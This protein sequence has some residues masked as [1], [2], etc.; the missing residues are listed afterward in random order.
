MRTDP[1]HVAPPDPRRRRRSTRVALGAAV[2]V[3]LG[4]SGVY[5][6]T[7][8]AAETVV[9]GRLQAEAFSAQSGVRIEN[10][11][12][13]D[14]G[15]NVGWL[16][17]GDWLRYDNVTVGSTVT[18]R[19]ASDNTAGGSIELRLGSPTG[20]LLTTIPVARTGGWQ[21]WVTRTATV[22]APAGKQKLVA[23]MTS[24]QKSDFVN[25]NWFTVGG[26][27]AP[28]KPVATPS[29]K[30]TAKP[31]TA[32][33]TAAPTTTAPAGNTGAGWIPVDQ[34]KWQAQLT[35]FNAMKPKAI[36]GNPVR[37]A[38][39]NASCTVSH[40]RA[41]DPIV[42][43]GLPG[44]SHMHSFL[45]NDATDAF[46]TTDTLLNNAGSSCK[47]LQDRSAYWIPTLYENGKA[48]EPHGVTVYYGSRL[49]DPTRTVPFPQGFR[50]IVGD[51]KRQVATPKGAHSQFWCAGIGGEQGRSADG[52]WPVCAKTAE[53]TFQLTFP[54]CWD[55]VHLDSPDHKSHVGPADGQGKCSGK[56]PVAIPSVSFVIGYKTSGSS[57][58][59]KLSSGNA[60]SMHGDAFLAW[61]NAALG[62]RVK[63]CIVQKAK[64]DTFGN[65]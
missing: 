43:P 10:T 11:S 58:G 45:G 50:M 23:I 34:A 5:I 38:E 39:F 33:A 63:D 40:S 47:P 61:D 36:T 48:I 59:F 6:A 41:D 16:A 25:I 20:T 49:P 32:P 2:A 24:S 62:H 13:R 55:G 30:P 15:R 12:D 65:H 26:A 29:S 21:K 1:Q 7:A 44:G 4:G 28:A 19:I 57:A 64:C 46:T 14:G 56:F 31:T 51:A 35:Q 37:V 22:K 9:P 54:D 60:S 8:N 42:L 18:A 53:L 3:A 17:N 52:N 27:A